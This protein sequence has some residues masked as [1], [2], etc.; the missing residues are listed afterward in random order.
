[1]LFLQKRLRYDQKSILMNQMSII[2]NNI[3]CEIS[4]YMNKHNW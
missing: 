2:P 3:K 1:M 4:A